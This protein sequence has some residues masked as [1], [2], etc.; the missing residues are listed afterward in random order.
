M[1][2][3]LIIETFVTV[4]VSI[5]MFPI[6]V[7]I[8][9]NWIEILFITISISCMVMGFFNACV[10]TPISTNLQNLVPDEIRSNFFAVLGMFSQ[11]AIPIG[12]LVFGILLDIMRYH[13]ILI[14]I[15]L[16]LIFVV[17]C[18]LIKAPDEYEAADDS[19]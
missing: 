12:C 2:S 8:F 14:I 6:I 1:K 16:L 11:A 19:L 4:I 13:F 17:A 7:N 3:G 9:K 5:L 10:N 18:F 15:N